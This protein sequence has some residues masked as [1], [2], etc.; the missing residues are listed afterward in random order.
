MARYRKVECATMT[1][2]RFCALSA[3]QPNGQTLWMYLLCGQRTTTFPG[4]VVGREEVMASDLQWPV[5]AFRKAFGEVCGQSLAKA[6]W[7]AG[8]VMLP[9]ALMDS[10]G[11]PRE[12]SKP[13]SPNVIKAWAKS[14]DEIPDSPLKAEYLIQLGFF[15]K[16]LG[17][18]FEEAYRVSFRKALAK[19]SPYPS[20]IQEQEKEQEQEQEKP[21][22]SAAPP[23]GR[24]SPPKQPPSPE[25]VSAARKLLGLISAKSPASTLA[26]AS[27]SKR[28]DTALKWSVDIRKLHEIDGHPW[29]EINGIIDWCQADSFW[30]SNIL[31]GKKLREK[32][33]QLAV[34]RD[35]RSGINGH[36]NRDP[37][38]G[39]VL[40]K[41]P[42]AY[43]DGDHTFND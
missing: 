20:P 26:R 41:P 32:W 30:S 17:V 28:E 40:A 10:T 12:S 27:E 43:T 23:R 11:E 33:D 36:A 42:S 18:S 3:P 6:D 8:L 24:T 2:A 31:S 16:G 9:K 1:D 13:Q 37:R 21:K 25:A 4:L 35:S 22:T 7:K 15:T 14:W 38:Y 19:P 39:A 34:K 5:E 29:D